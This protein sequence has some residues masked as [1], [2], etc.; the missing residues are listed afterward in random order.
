LTDA[1]SALEPP[2]QRPAPD[3]AS[4]RAVRAQQLK[5]VLHKLAKRKMEGLQLYRSLPAAERFHACTSRI[6]LL[7]GSN[8]AGRTLAGECEVARCATGTD[9]FGKYAKEGGVI[10]AVGYDEEH[11][12]DPMWRRL[13]RPGA[14]N[15]IRD[16]HTGL[17]RSVRP[18]PSNPLRLDPYDE[19]YR[20]K[21]QDAPPLLPERCIRKVAW[22]DRGKD[23]PRHVVTTNNW[24]ILWR[25][26]K[27]DAVRGIQINLWHFDEEIKNHQFLP[28]CLRGCMRYDGVGFWSATPQS[29]GAQLYEL[30]LR[31]ASEDPDVQAFPLY[32]TENP[33]YTDEAKQAFHDA[34]SED[35]RRV[36]WYGEYAIA[37]QLC[38]RTYDP[39]GIHGCEPKEIPPDWCV[40][41]IVDPGS[42][43]CG[44][45]FG[46]IDP[47]EAHLWV[48]DGFDLRNA[49]AQMWAVEVGK[50]LRGR[51][52]ERVIIDQRMGKQRPPSMSVGTNVASEYFAALLQA[53]VRPRTE[54]PLNGFF[55][56]SDD[57]DG[58][59]EAVRGLLAIRGDGPFSGTPT[60]QVMRG[61][62]PQLDQ[63]M[64][65]AHRKS[66]RPG[67]RARHD[68]M[69]EDVLVTLEYWAASKPGYHPPVV[70][71]EGTTPSVLDNFNKKCARQRR[72]R[73]AASADFGPGMQLG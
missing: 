34:L 44:T 59:E 9:P 37:G 56:G 46:A 17:I 19:A 49:D 60:L 21:W 65:L 64:R 48:Y 72:R 58:R 62:V 2:P 33:F 51:V 32:I 71:A 40:E 35:E 54:G 63:Q 68:L 13:A 14:F 28:E 10:L 27:G 67:K 29:G 20:E 43:H 42:Q 31:A 69:P 57:V 25:S 7:D 4:A 38:Y 23:V 39:Q 55:P 26:S 15:T 41:V 18:D 66:D 53:G 73:S 8:Q 50:R 5:A 47:A 52:P 1:F 24:K 3:G 12:G 45:L 70:A 61:C 11:I 22:E 36:R 30:H 16:E 6:R